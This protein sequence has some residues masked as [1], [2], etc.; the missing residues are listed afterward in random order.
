MKLFGD[1]PVARKAKKR[2]DEYFDGRER[3]TPKDFHEHFFKKEEISEEVTI[4]V[5]D[6]FEN[7]LEYDFSRISDIDDFS[8]ELS[9][10]WEIDSLAD[11]E[12]V[13][14]LEE[15]FGI[16]ISEEEARSM[17][18]LRKVVEHIDTKLKSRTSR[19]EQCR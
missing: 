2:L 19:S 7:Q 12:I 6:V 13:M 15:N 11:V 5:L 10:M 14:A 18:T 17:T 16:E 4:K 3:L 9:V 8:K 1:D